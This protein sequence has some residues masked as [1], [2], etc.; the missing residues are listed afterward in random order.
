[1]H[2]LESQIWIGQHQL[3]QEVLALSTWIR[4]LLGYD[5]QD[6]SKNQRIHEARVHAYGHQAYTYH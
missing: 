2:L 5:M 3:R 1:M 6:N 4:T